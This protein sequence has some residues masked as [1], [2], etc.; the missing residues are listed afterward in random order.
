MR[1]TAERLPTYG[2]CT[3]VSRFYT[4]VGDEFYEFYPDRE[5]VGLWLHCT[6]EVH[7]LVG[8]AWANFLAFDYGADPAAAL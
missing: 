7:R 4:F 6:E 3:D 5:S 2:M 8:G 1:S